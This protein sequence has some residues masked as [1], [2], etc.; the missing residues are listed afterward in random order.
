MLQLTRSAF[1]CTESPESLAEMRRCFDR[2]HGIHL[3]GFLHPQLLDIAQRSIREASFYDRADEDLALEQCMHNNT[4]VAMLYLIVN[5]QGLLG[6][7]RHIT[8]CDS[9][10]AFIGRVYQMRSG[11]GHYARWHNDLYGARRIGM[12]VNL[13]DGEF[14]GGIFEL[15]EADAPT[16]RWAIAN[17]GPGD[18]ILFRVAEGLQHRVTPIEGHVARIAFAGWFQSGP[19]LLSL[20]K[21]GVDPRN[22]PASP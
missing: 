11:V 8:G 13:S 16:V 2:S 17:T 9:I 22:R 12:S 7:V 21:A 5:D 10:T 19:D 6:T 15:R 4:L 1:V 20:L 18:A 14:N 3:P